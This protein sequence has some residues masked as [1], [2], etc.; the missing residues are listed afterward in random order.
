[1][2]TN[3]AVICPQGTESGQIPKCDEKP[4]NSDRH[5]MSDMSDMG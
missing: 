3:L 2:L 1:M 4:Q 5:H